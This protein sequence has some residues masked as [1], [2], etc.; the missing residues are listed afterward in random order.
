M[1]ASHFDL[2][3]VGTGAGGG[4]MAQALAA[5]AH[6]FWSSSAAGSCRLRS[7]TG[8]RRPSGATCAIAPPSAGSTSEASGSCR[9]RTTASA[10]TRSSGAA[11]C[12]GCAARTSRKS[13][14]PTGCRPP[15]PSTTRRSRPTT[16][17][18]NGSITC[19]ARSATT[20]RSRR[21]GRFRMRPSRTPAGMALLVEQLRAQGLHPSALPLGLLN[22][23]APG[24]CILCNTC[25]SFPCK[26]HAKS[27]AE[28][29]GIRA[30]VAHPNVTLW[31]DTLAQ[32]LIASADGARVDAVEVLR[33]G[34]V[35]RVE[36]PLVVVSCG[37]VNSA[38]LLL[39]SATRTHPSGL[40]N[41][42]GLVGRRYMAHLATMMQGV[43]PVPRERH[44]VS[45]DRRHQRLLPP[46]TGPPLSARAD[47][48]PGTHARR[49]GAGGRRH[50]GPRDS[51]VGL[52]L[53]GRAWR[54]LARDV[55]GPAPSRQPG[56]GGAGWP[57]PALVC[58]QQRHRP[59]GAG[60]P[61]PHASFAGSASGK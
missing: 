50:D 1:R 51:A 59:P 53:V 31:T 30:A 49:D 47:S 61:R 45:E 7:R 39:R 10:A 12:T 20:P 16:S 13:H 22:P 34:Q 37:A 14:T 48:V 4:T 28:V 54:G 9:I 42:S 8:A 6:G 35:Q 17:G 15:G 19:T 55:R 18:P 32:R 5:P 33:E 57:D 27:D 40:A 56:D 21:A 43:P 25:N 23:G 36:A 11:C 46:G 58:A 38:A 52:R 29:C 60:Q 41:S 44:G 26:L 2:I 24:G 3:I